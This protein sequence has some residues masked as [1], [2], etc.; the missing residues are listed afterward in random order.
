MS[1]EGQTAPVPSGEATDYR[2]P[3]RIVGVDFSGD[4]RAAGRKIWLAEATIEGD[5]V[6]VRDCAPVADR[7]DVSAAREESIPALTRFLASLPESAAVGLDFPFGLPREV[8]PAAS[9][10]AFLR[11]FPGWFDSPDA[12]RRRCRERAAVAGESGQLFRATD[13]HLGALSPWN[14]RLRTQTFFGIRDVLRPLALAAAVRAAPMQA[15]EPD[16]PTLLEVYPAATL[17]ELD[18]DATGYKDGGEAARERRADLVDRLGDEGVDLADEMRETVVEDDAGDALDSVLAA[19]AAA[20]NAA[21]PA[22][23]HTTH[24]RLRVEGYVYV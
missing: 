10:S 13:E 15:P 17:A 21:D 9:W 2:P 24:E 16:R 7:L 20:R 23:L 8:V 12:L 22:N 14:L 4:A 18:C 1:H 5:G 19:F 3:E 11:A 6:R